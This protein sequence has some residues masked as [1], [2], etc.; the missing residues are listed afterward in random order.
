VVVASSRSPRD[1]QF[2]ERLGFFNPIASGRAEALR[3]DMERI[4]HWMMRGAIISHRVGALVK[5]LNTTS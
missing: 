4:N 5:K 2:I 1:G 3:L